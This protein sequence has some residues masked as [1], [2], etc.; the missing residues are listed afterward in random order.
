M[1]SFEDAAHPT[2]CQ[3]Q[4][5]RAPLHNHGFNANDSSVPSSA[6]EENVK[7]LIAGAIALAEADDL[8]FK[9]DHDDGTTMTSTEKA[10]RF[11]DFGGQ[12]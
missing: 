1:T 5:R 8:A 6:Y 7:S 2:P 9:A 10:G 3:Q 4:C 12:L 11:S